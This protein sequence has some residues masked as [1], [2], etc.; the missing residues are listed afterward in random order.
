MQTR[1]SRK[2]EP[3]TIPGSPFRASDP[4]PLLDPAK[5]ERVRRL[6]PP[7]QTGVTPKIVGLFLDGT[8]DL[9]AAIHSGA[10]NNDAG[11]VFRAAHTLKDVAGEVGALRLSDLADRLERSARMGN[12][13]LDE[14]LGQ[15]D[16][17]LRDTLALLA[18]ERHP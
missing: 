12:L 10:S 13:N 5:L 2:A 14:A 16:K 7:D 8:P 6:Q 4:S 17:T 1:S 11:A 18:E 15:L 3:A 9:V